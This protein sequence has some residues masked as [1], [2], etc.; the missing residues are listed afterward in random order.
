[1]DFTVLPILQY[2]PETESRT[3]ESFSRMLDEFLRAPGS[4]RPGTP[5]GAGSGQGGDQRQGPHGPA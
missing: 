5:A 2:G 1:M 3:Q 4:G